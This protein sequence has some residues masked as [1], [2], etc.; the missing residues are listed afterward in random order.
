MEEKLA[1]RAL[2]SLQ[3]AIEAQVVTGILLAAALLTGVITDLSLGLTFGF[4]LAV[5]CLGF[6]HGTLRVLR[7]RSFALYLAIYSVFMH[8]VLAVL[9]AL[10]GQSMAWPFVGMCVTG[11][12]FTLFALWT[13]E[14][15]VVPYLRNS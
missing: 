1:L 5:F 7:A 11:T 9:F 4:G 12:L 10:N 8:W 2:R 3:Y 15:K 14:K 13:T 6:A